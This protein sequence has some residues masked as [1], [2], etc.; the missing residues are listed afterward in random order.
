[1][2]DH[3]N[4]WKSIASHF[5]RE[6]STVMRWASERG[7]PVHRYPGGKKGGVYANIDELDLWAARETENIAGP[8]NESGASGVTAH[9]V[10]RGAN[11]TMARRRATPYPRY[12]L[13]A[14]LLVTI[15]SLGL[16]YAQGNL[17]SVGAEAT[18]L[19][20]NPHA[21][22]LYLR[23]RDDWAKRQPDALQRSIAVLLQVTELEPD[24]APAYAALA[25]SYLLSREFGSLEDDIAFPKAMDA[26]KMA[27]KLDPSLADAHRAR[28]FVSYWWD[29]END[30]AGRAFQRALELDPEVAQT[31]FWY[32][33]ILS[34]NG[35]HQAG[36][37]ELKRARLLEPGSIAIQT[38]FAWALWSAGQE[39]LA[40]G[41][42][43][44]IA[45]NQPNFAVAH[46]CLA[47]IRL[48]RGDYD[49]FI[50]E[51]ARVAEIRQNVAMG[52]M[53][54]ELRTA[55][56]SGL[57]AL[58]TALMASALAEVRHGVRR[59]HSWPAFLASVAGD[60]ETLRALLVRADS[61]KEVWGNSGLR[62]QIA[63]RW[64]DDGV[65]MTLLDRRA[66][67][68]ID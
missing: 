67:L 17:F 47:T 53:I 35:E 64:A 27:A 12:W 45:R 34:D 9:P 61:R 59:E 43:E 58:Q 3:L 63:K 36:L 56:A 30:A 22:Q 33:N 42:L 4:G 32:G 11:R 29:H 62:A 16:F 23:A 7:L 5:G 21:A 1:M 39:E 49:G 10:E 24:F 13:V 18:R 8:D 14:L 40:L 48:A 60:R 31:R 28:G 19:P 25:D 46:E 2:S 15:A 50:E 37:R 55:R 26:A 68:R 65:I 41:Q 38:D 54:S 66:G 6:R 44:E 57:P 51:T 52:K 20:D